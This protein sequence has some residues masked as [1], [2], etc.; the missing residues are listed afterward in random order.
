MNTVRFVNDLGA[1]LVLPLVIAAY[2]VQTKRAI[3]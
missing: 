2:F 3:Q 1:D